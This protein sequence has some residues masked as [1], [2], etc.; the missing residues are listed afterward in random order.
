MRDLYPGYDV[1]AKRAT[2]SW[3]DATRS[4]VDARMAVHPGPR[5]LDADAFATLQALCD[6]ILPQ[7]DRAQSIPL[8]ANVDEKLWLDKRAGY[9]NAKLPPIREAW[10]RGLVALEAE[11]QEA[12]G[13][14]FTALDSTSQ[15]ALIARMSAGDLHAAAWGDMPC[16]LFFSERVMAEIPRAYYAHPAAWNEIGFGG[17]ASPRGYVRL[18]FDKRDPWE[19]AEAKPGHEAEARKANARVGR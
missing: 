13:R 12:H 3:N 19:A 7:G 16:A 14:S 8:A 2:P 4:A 6:R 17:P 10:S 5:F 9:R 18:D 11:A 15:D 1:A